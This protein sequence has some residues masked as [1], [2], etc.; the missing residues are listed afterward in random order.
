MIKN[1]NQTAKTEPVY[2]GNYTIVKKNQ[3]ESYILVDITGA[4][5]PRNKNNLRYDVEAVIDHK[6]TP[7]NWLYLARWKGYSA[8][9]D[10]WE[11]EKHFHDNR[12][13]LKYWNHRNGQRD[14]EPNSSGN[15]SSHKR[16]RN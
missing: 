10:T 16:A 14:V 8:K 12:L 7:G 1:I 9:N 11:P 3:G 15:N 13:I 4:F 5:L 6:G 2:I